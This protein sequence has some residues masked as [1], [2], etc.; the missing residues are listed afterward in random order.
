MK[1]RQTASL[2]RPRP[3][4]QRPGRRL[5]AGS[6]SIGELREAA[7]R[8]LPK[9]IF[10]YVDG[11]SDDEVTLRRN[12]SAFDSYQLFPRVLRDVTEIDVS[13]TVLG[14]RSALPLV[15]GP[16]G[17]NR[18]V[19]PD[20]EC[21]VARAAAA[22]GIPYAQSGLS[23]YAMEDVATASS[24]RR[25]F[26][27]YVWR[28]RGM[29]KE[30]IARARNAGCEAIVLTVDVPGGVA[31]LKLRDLR[32]GLTMPPSLSW[33]SLFGGAVHPPW[34]WRFLTSETLRFG[35]VGDRDAD[36]ADTFQFVATQLDPGI[37][38][39]DL[40]WVSELWDGPI[41]VKGLVTTEDARL[42]VAAGASAIVV[43]NHG[44]R[45]LDQ[46]V[47]PIDVLED[48][49]QAVG[50]DVEV[51]LD[52]GVRRGS[53]IVKAI[54]LGANACLVGRAYLYGLAVD[55][56]R[57]VARAVELLATEIRRTMVLLGARTMAEVEPSMVRQLDRS[58]AATIGGS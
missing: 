57:G 4:E 21:A 15:L 38:W 49:V 13:T 37:T 25:W 44:G 20:G 39:D 36:Q 48:I 12:I 56:E 35:N 26:Q 47:A 27:M 55:G 23:N 19:H 9:G 28:D 50:D 58:L 14:S 32:N 41:V 6:H 17:C 54:A 7:R 8:R 29:C 2:L 18:L 42:A 52:S 45:Q 22:A 24:G 10:D 40:A 1:L 43:S 5:A 31:G 53:D 33:R 16:T 3:F 34:A 51:L 11:G 46:V 30:L